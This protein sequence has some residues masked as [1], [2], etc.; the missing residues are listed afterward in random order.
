MQYIPMNILFKKVKSLDSVQSQMHEILIQ[1]QVEE[2]LE[3][4]LQNK[5]LFRQ[6]KPQKKK[7]RKKVK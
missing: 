4:S 3:F 6:N 5:T 1:T 7:E 2:L